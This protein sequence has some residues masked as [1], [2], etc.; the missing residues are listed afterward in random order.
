MVPA[1]QAPQPLASQ[2]VDSP[3]VFAP[4]TAYLARSSFGPESANKSTGFLRQQD[5]SSGFDRDPQRQRAS[6]F[7]GLSNF[8][9]SPTLISLSSGN[10]SGPPSAKHGSSSQVQTA[11]HSPIESLKKFFGISTQQKEK[12][13]E[14]HISVTT[15]QEIELKELE[16]NDTRQED[17]VGTGII[18]QATSMAKHYP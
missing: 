5:T 13:M 2:Y 9:S 8:A 1:G 15:Y 7:G 12:D 16:N 18:D 17:G 4:P 3:V 14:V 6:S 11:S 10:L